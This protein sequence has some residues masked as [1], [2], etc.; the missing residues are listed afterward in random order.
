MEEI[1]AVTSLAALAQVQRLR[2]FRTLI[3]AAPQGLTPGALSTLLD[4]PASTLSFHLKEMMHA[5]LVA[6]QRDGRNLIYSPSIERM[7]A[8]LITLSTDPRAGL[9]LRSDPQ[10]A[11]GHRAHAGVHRDAAAARPA[12]PPVR[13]EPVCRPDR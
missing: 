12:P 4:V 3:G 5:G 1:A 13:P 2:V 7:N 6:Q 8:L 9:A 10:L 11:V